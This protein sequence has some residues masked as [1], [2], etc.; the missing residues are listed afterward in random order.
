M[1]SDRYRKKIVT[2]LDH[3]IR[4]GGEARERVVHRMSWM[5][6]NRLLTNAEEVMMAGS[7]WGDDYSSYNDLP[8]ISRTMDWGF[9]ILPEPEN[10]I[11][12]ERYREKWLNTNVSTVDQIPD[13]DALLFN[14]GSAVYGLRVHNRSFIFTKQEI[15]FLGE[16]ICCWAK[17]PAPYPLNIS[18]LPHIQL[19]YQDE[20]SGV[21]DA[22]SGLKFLLL[23]I[24]LSED[25]VKTLFDKF[26]KLNESETPAFSL[27][28]GLIKSLPSLSDDIAQLM[29]I[30]LVSSKSNLALD[31][32]MGLSFWLEVSGELGNGLRP[33]PDDLVRDIGFI[34][35]LRRRPVLNLAL[36]IAK[37]VFSDG[38]RR[39]QTM[40]GDLLSRGL[41]YLAHELEYNGNYDQAD[42]V[43]LLRLGCTHLA[44]AMAE[45]GFNKD[46]NVAFWVNGSK[47]DALPEIR[48][49]NARLTRR[50]IDTVTLADHK[51]REF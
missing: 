28:A 24:Y 41:G 42:D 44:I 13:I 45:H 43:P 49:A 12:E 9:L 18:A 35:A 48:H 30:S 7:L 50:P 19:S 33:P 4:V 31:S 10:G 26:I 25:V 17:V 39:H 6:Y 2:F 46:S 36:Q 29:R 47:A 3:A 1:I 23:G 15:E 5:Y 37:W 11:A 21:F 20:M 27:S 22:I 34:I 38:E 32:A 14:V 8:E 51:D 16:V 40:L